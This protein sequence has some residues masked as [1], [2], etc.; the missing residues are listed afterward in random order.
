MLWLAIVV[1]VVMF[2]RISRPAAWLLV[3]YLL[4]VTYAASLT[5]AIWRLN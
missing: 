5:I 3:P 4:W 1:N 2:R